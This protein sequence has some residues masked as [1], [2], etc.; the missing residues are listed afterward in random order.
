MRRIIGGRDSTYGNWPWQVSISYPHLGYQHQHLCG[1]VLLNH[2]W[3]LTAAHCVVGSK[4]YKVRI[5][6]HHTKNIFKEDEIQVRSISKIIS[7][8]RF[9]R[10]WLYMI[11]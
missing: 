2:Q 8:D 6:V 4:Q 5:G 10:S 1:G 7:H 3:V 11:G 9:N